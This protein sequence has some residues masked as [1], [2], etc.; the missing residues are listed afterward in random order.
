MTNQTGS[1]PKDPIG[2]RFCQIFT[3]GWHF[4]FAKLDSLGY[5][6]RNWSTE[7][8][9]PIQPRNLWKRYNDP[10]QIIGL[11]FGEKTNYLV[12]DIDRDSIYHPKRSLKKYKEIIY[13]LEDIGLVRYIV[14]QSS[15]SEGIHI[16]FFLPKKVPTFKLAVT[17]QNVLEDNSYYVKKGQLEI[18]PNPK[19]YGTKHKT[20]YNGIRLPL[21]PNT[22]S[23]ILDDFSLDPVSDSIEEFLDLA[24][25]TAQQQDIET[26]KK[27]ARRSQEE[28]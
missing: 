20:N 2:A 19:A 4:I 22:G 21:Q 28:T 18:F 13:T 27:S 24:E 7:K 8:K 12:L 15:H 6:A 5:L 26:L 23:Y 25:S 3:H 9:Y 1:L 17:V 10:S 11:R 16:Y 14:I